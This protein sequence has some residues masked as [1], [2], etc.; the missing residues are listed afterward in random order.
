MCAA[1]RWPDPD[2]VIDLDFIIR[3][4]EHRILHGPTYTPSMA[5]ID[6]MVTA[7]GYLDRLEIEEL[8]LLKRF[9]EGQR[10]RRSPTL[11][12]A[13]TAVVVRAMRRS[14]D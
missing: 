7:M 6:L 8:E 12:P 10:I 14:K 4:G 5:E 11:T 2:R 1:C 13:E 3:K 9:Q